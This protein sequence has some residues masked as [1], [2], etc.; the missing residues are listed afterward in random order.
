MR[1]YLTMLILVGEWR[2][3]GW[4]ISFK[5]AQLTSGRIQS[6][7][8][9]L[10]GY[11]NPHYT[12]DVPRQVPSSW[13]QAGVCRLTCWAAGLGNSSPGVRVAGPASGL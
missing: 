1:R 7:L 12:A 5:I 6:Q 10:W 11:P 13:T 4:A 3:K 8:C 2:L 9:G